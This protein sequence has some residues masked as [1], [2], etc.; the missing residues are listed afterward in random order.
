MKATVSSAKFRESAISATESDLRPQ[1]IRGCTKYSARPVSSSRCHA[2][3][4]SFLLAMDCRM[5][6]ESSS[7]MT[8][9]ISGGTVTF[10]SS[11]NVPRHS[12]L[13]RSQIRHFTSFGFSGTRFSSRGLFRCVRQRGYG[14]LGQNQLADLVA[15]LDD[16][17]QLRVPVCPGNH[18]T[19]LPTRRCKYLNRDGRTSRGVTCA[20]VLGQHAGD[21][22]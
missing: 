2:G 19:V 22:H 14:V 18:M 21:H 6:R 3:S 12:V 13:S 11:S 7:A 4:W 10:S 5:P 16:L 15:A 8:S 17:H 1:P 9:R 20:H